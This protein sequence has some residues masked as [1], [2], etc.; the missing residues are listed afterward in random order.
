MI[1]HKKH[2]IIKE[3]RRGIYMMS[4]IQKILDGICAIVIL[5]ILTFSLLYGIGVK[6]YLMVTGSMDP[7]IP[8]GSICFINTNYSF[9]KLATQDIIMYQTPKQR[10]IHRIIEKKEDGYKTKG[11]ANSK[12]DVKTITSDLYL[13]KYVF[14]IP[15]L[16][17]FTSKIDGPIEKGIFLTCLIILF[18]VDYL[19][20]YATKQKVPRE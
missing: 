16:G 12:E 3:S 20:H 6:P 11:D 15:K 13:G 10:V 9:Q 7:T 17:Y 5:C 18:S 2:E 14:S 1:N 19:V 8:I 4:I